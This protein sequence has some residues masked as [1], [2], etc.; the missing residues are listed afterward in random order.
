MVY[1][2]RE[3]LINSGDLQKV[4]EVYILNKEPGSYIKEI[5][6]TSLSLRRLGKVTSVDITLPTVF[7]MLA[8][9]LSAKS[10]P[11]PGTCAP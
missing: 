6:N 8:A 3:E 10:L 2:M 11:I 1:T 5:F 4:N 9:S 7:C